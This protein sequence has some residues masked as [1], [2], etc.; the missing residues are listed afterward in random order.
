MKRTLLISSALCL[1]AGLLLGG[2][3][4]MP[5]DTNRPAPVA[6]TLVQA[7]SSDQSG[8]SAQAAPVPLNSSDNFTLLNTACYAIQALRT[9]DYAAVASLVHPEKGV[10][11]TPFSTVNFDTDL[12][13]SQSEIRNLA[14]DDTVYSWG[15][16]DG[17]GELIKMTMEQ[18]FASYVFNTDY[19]QASLIGV[20]QIMLSG[21]ALENV[22][23]S[24]PGCRFVDFSIPSQSN[25][26]DGLDW[27][28][29]KL[30]FEPGDTAWYLVG[31]VH[32][33]WTV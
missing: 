10:T 26:Y 28:S 21:N 2:L 17:Q 30:V 14:E 18:Y 5:W 15:F 12:N 23:E 33:Q 27:C 9:Q 25:S 29:L 24:Y 20:D 13:F 22:T 6:N 31:V 8:V 4:P 1:V 19:S 32:G 7:P 16:T 11:F 3:L